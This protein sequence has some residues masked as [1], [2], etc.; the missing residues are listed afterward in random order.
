[1]SAFALM[2]PQNQ[3]FEKMV[4]VSCYGFIINHEN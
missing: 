3:V 2:H 1:M 4:S